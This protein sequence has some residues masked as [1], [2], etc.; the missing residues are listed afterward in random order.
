MYVTAAGEHVVFV[1]GCWRRSCVTS[2]AS[3]AV[4]RR[5]PTNPPP[6]SGEFCW[7]KPTMFW[8]RFV[9][10]THNIQNKLLLLLKDY[11]RDF[12]YLLTVCGRV[13]EKNATH[14]T[15]C[16][17]CLLLRWMLCCQRIPSSRWWEGW[18][19]I[20]C[21]PSGGRRW[22]CWTTNCSTG[23]SGRNNRYTSLQ[24]VSIRA[25][26]CNFD[27]GSYLWNLLTQVRWSR[28]GQDSRCKLRH[29]AV[30]HI[31]VDWNVKTYFLIWCTGNTFFNWRM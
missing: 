25:V 20:S 21:R 31:N 26:R 24:I 4:W 28:D 19:E 30:M 23:R 27:F 16:S 14:Q 10:F 13:A 3:L 29:Q 9:D 2:T 15:H 12:F 17:R 6:S 5:T 11:F 7:I 8:I 22:S 1:S 18:W